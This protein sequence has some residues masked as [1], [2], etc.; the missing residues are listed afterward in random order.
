MVVARVIV[1]AIFVHLTL[2]TI[3]T[4]AVVRGFVY[5]KDCDEIQK[6]FQFPCLDTDAL[7]PDAPYACQGFFMSIGM[8]I[9]GYLAPKLGAKRTCMIGCLCHSTGV[10]LA[11][12]AIAQRSEALFCLTYGVF[13]GLGCGIGYSGPLALLLAWMPDNK[14][15]A[16]GIVTAGFGAGTFI[17]SRVQL[18]LVNSSVVDIPNMGKLLV[19]DQMPLFFLQLGAI[20]ACLQIAGLWLLLPPPAAA[21]GSGAAPV[22]S[23]P[24]KDAIRARE[25]LVMLLLFGCQTTG[26][27][28]TSNY[29]R[30]LVTLSEGGGLG[31]LTWVVPIGALGNTLG[32]LAF[33]QLETTAGFKTTLMVNSGCLVVLHGLLSVVDDAQ[34]V[35][36]LVF[37]LW[38]C[39]GGNFAIFPTNTAKT[40]GPQF[41]AL[42]Y[43]VVFL[44]FGTS[45]LCVG[46][47][48]KYILPALSSDP[49]AALRKFYGL[50]ACQAAFVFGAV[51]VGAVRMPSQVQH[52][53]KDMTG[54]RLVELAG[55]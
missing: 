1:G 35:V 2:G 7:H 26:V 6:H 12:Y 4:I 46:L 41:F 51:A 29:Q 13:F 54:G 16:S 11:S 44:G 36:C 3:Y 37:C 48:A 30:D 25:M 27:N 43:A 50:L 45:G 34:V 55:K 21:S 14:G 31:L 28:L 39:F 42:N 17:F 18:A 22:F 33:G 5:R 32:R 24:L 53:L 19:Y 15:L 8:F 20:Y 23:V 10:L 38:F 40:F 9:G 49:G 47:N 52:M